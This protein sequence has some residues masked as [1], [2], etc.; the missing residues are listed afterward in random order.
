MKTI[1]VIDDD[2]LD[3]CAL[4][5]TIKS[6]CDDVAIHEL[7]SGE[8]AVEMI[9]SL[10]PDHTFLDL[11]MP[12]IDGFGVLQAVSSARLEPKPNI[13][14]VSTSDYIDDKKRALELGCTDYH[15]KPDS[16]AGYRALVGSILNAD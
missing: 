12:G 3:R 15:V 10:K 9:S 16:R 4:K 1:L 11:W 2:D 7:D 5:R 8:A 13:H 6:I 14:I